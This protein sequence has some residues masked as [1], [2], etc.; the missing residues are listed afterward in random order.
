MQ[1]E[2]RNQLSD[3]RAQGNRAERAYSEFI[4]PFIEAMNKQLYDAFNSVSP[5]D[6]ASLA[7][8]R[9]TQMVVNE[10]EANIKEFITTGNMASLMLNQE[11]NDD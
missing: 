7:D 3:E 8:I 9:R 4:K 2:Q 11:K 10:L 1:P 6:T 5:I